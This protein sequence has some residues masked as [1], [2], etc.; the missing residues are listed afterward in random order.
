MGEDPGNISA[1]EQVECLSAAAVRGAHAGTGL[2]V[3][4]KGCVK[5]PLVRLGLWLGRVEGQDLL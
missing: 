5:G 1:V 4:V 2:V 3:S